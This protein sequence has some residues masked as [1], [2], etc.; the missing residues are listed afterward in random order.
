MQ[1]LRKP[2]SSA[3]KTIE[4]TI[5]QAS[6]EAEAA[7]EDGTLTWADMGTWRLSCEKDSLGL[8]VWFGYMP[9]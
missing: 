9:S 6:T 2:R 8:L 5:D 4:G 3:Q 1:R 7:A